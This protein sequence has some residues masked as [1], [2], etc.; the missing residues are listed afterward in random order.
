MHLFD[1]ISK[2]LYPLMV[3]SEDII[4]EPDMLDSVHLFQFT[5]L[6]R[7]ALGGANLKLVPEIGLAHQLQR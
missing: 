3:E 5:N 7:N 4:S 1:L 6:R 2:I